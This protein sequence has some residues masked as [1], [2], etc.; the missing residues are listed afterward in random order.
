VGTTENSV[1]EALGRAHAALLADLRELE[2]AAR[3]SSGEGVAELRAR[4][5]ATQRHVTEQCDGRRL[6]PAR[7]IKG[8]PSS[9]AALL[10]LGH[11][12]TDNRTGKYGT[13]FGRAI[14]AD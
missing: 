10:V 4:L 5:V 7:P 1:A 13:G 8:L 12:L 6:G 14:H 9:G 3:P 11:R 2:Q